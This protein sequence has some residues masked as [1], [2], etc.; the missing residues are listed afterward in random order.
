MDAEPDGEFWTGVCEDSG[1]WISVVGSPIAHV[2]VA[3]VL[4][5][6]AWSIKVK[7]LVF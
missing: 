4:K 6:S 5:T 7:N 3:A 1:W 2:Y